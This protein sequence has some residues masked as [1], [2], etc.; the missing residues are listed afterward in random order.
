MRT[1]F[2]LYPD[3]A[4]LRSLMEIIEEL[5]DEPYPVKWEKASQLHITMKFIAE[6]HP[7]ALRRI[8][9]DVRSAF[10]GTGAISMTLDTLDAFP[11]PRKPR[12]IWIGGRSMSS[13]INEIQAGIEDVASKNGIPRERNK[14]TPHFT[15]GRVKTYGEPPDL[16]NAL[17]SVSFMSFKTE[18]REIRIM[19]SALTPK[20][21]IHTE[22]DR[23]PLDTNSQ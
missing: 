18:F 21:A 15:I 7:D 13:R 22:V 8:A 2:A 12:I 17:N 23:I 3:E 10:E 19:E 4:G 14:F 6:I 11:N 1:F 9:G 20:G 16:K 5:G